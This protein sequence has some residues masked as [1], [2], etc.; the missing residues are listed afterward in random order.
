MDST[1]T[2]LDTTL[3][4][5]D[6]NPKL[7]LNILVCGHCIGEQDPMTIFHI[8]EYKLLC[9]LKANIEQINL[10]MFTLSVNIYF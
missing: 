7:D 4:V 5:T 9:F 8:H 10:Y 2:N 6:L 1:D 3:T